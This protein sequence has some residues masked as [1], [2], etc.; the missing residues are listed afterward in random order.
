MEAVILRRISDGKIKNADQA[1]KSVAG[2]L[3][4]QLV[5]Y[6]LAQ[7]I[8][9]GNITAE[10]KV[11]LTGKKNPLLSRYATIQVGGDVQ[12][13]D[14]DVLVYAAGREDTPILNFSCKTSCR[15]RAGQPYKWKLLS[16]L[17]TCRCAHKEENP[18]CPITRYKLRYE[19]ARPVRI[20]FV[21]ADFYH[22]LA[23][24]QIAAMFHFFD[25]AYIAKAQSPV[26]AVQTFDRVVED[27]NRCYAE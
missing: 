17:A 2:N 10:I 20:C 15:E 16:D 14:S 22:E 8:L 25:H 3:F 11:A 9:C 6:A 19:Q 24:P 5:A 27:I 12:K 4:Q 13:P 26:A 7:N 1:R 21:T 23:N 18:L